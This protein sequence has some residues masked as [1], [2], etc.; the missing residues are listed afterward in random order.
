MLFSLDHPAYWAIA[1][2][3]VLVAIILLVLGLC[4]ADKMFGIVEP[5]F[6]VTRI[7]QEAAV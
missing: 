4:N 2:V 7:D 3:Y 1:G 5:E 6:D